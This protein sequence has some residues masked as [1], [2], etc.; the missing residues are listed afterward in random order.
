MAAR[1]VAAAACWLASADDSS[2]RG[3]PRRE[4]SAEPEENTMARRRFLPVSARGLRGPRCSLFPALPL[5]AMSEAVGYLPHHGA[6]RRS[7]P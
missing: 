5:A 6:A 1:S 7:E 4:L 2:V 3:D